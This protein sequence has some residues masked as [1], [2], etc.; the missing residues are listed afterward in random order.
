MGNTA[1]LHLSKKKNRKI[2]QVWQ[3]APVLPAT[4]EAKV[5]GLPKP[6]KQ[7][8]GRG[9][10]CLQSQHFGSLKWV[11][12]LRKHC[13]KSSSN[14][15]GVMLVP[16][17][18]ELWDAKAGW[19]QWLTPEIP[20]LWEAEVDRP[21]GQ[22]IETILANVHFERQ[23]RVDHLSLGARDQP[24]Q[25]GETLKQQRIALEQ[26]PADATLS[27]LRDKQC[28]RDR[29]PNIAKPPPPA[30]WVQRFPQVSHF[31]NP[32]AAALPFTRTGHL[33]VPSCLGGS[34]GLGPRF[35]AVCPRPGPRAA[36]RAPP[37]AVSL[38]KFLSLSVS[39]LTHRKNIH[40][41]GMFRRFRSRHRTPGPREPCGCRCPQSRALWPREEPEAAEGWSV[42][43]SARLGAERQGG[44][45]QVTFPI[46]P[47]LAGDRGL[48]SGASAA[49]PRRRKGLAGREVAVQQQEATHHHMR[50]GQGE[51]LGADEWRH[52]VEQQH[53]GHEE[54]GCQ[55]QHHSAGQGARS[56]ERPGGGRQA[57]RAALGGGGAR[58]TRGGRAAGAESVWVCG[59]GRAAAEGKRRSRRGHHPGGA[60]LPGG[61]AAAARIASGVGSPGVSHSPR[62]GTGP[63]VRS[64]PRG[65]R[66]SAP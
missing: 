64:L 47:C 10:S 19:A 1:K 43:P 3:C 7:R 38:A 12:H 52:H 37:T 60:V 53:E 25:Q 46:R 16:V 15:P 61:A 29:R 63:T 62:L 11:D 56:P 34:R 58:I 28:R 14:K 57:G 39:Q 35:P 41:P 31:W 49:R 18:P 30:R 50:P 66:A 23:R 36:P 51:G 17:I 6:R 33:P 40:I 13:F 48:E 24:D 45:R 4:W 42:R 32:L 22:E 54:G 21:Q 27:E 20:S 26:P 8:A 44:R 9:G 55:Q 65:N 5:G 2:S 59:P